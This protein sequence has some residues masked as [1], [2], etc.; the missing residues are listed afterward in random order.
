[1]LNKLQ[2]SKPGQQP[3]SKKSIKKGRESRQTQQQIAIYCVL[4]CFY[5]VAFCCCSLLFLF[6]YILF[7]S[8]LQ[9][10]YKQKQTNHSK[11][12]VKLQR[13]YKDT[14]LMIFSY[15]EKRIFQQ[16]KHDDLMQSWSIYCIKKKAMCCPFCYDLMQWQNKS[17]HQPG[18]RQIRVS[19]QAHTPAP[20]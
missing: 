4:F 10:F 7:C 8:V 3:N 6:C 18:F 9:T 14:K 16:Q 1:M 2:T 19:G 20:Q 15:N 13:F 12:S 17:W 11:K 5:C